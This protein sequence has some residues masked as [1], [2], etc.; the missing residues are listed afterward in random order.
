MLGVEVANQGAALGRVTVG[1]TGASHKLSKGFLLALL[2]D[3]FV[4]GIMVVHALHK[5]SWNNGSS[6]AGHKHIVCCLESQSTVDQAFTFLLLE[7]H[8]QPG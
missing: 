7:V 2:D 1:Q 6:N 4:I 5:S 3:V 8:C